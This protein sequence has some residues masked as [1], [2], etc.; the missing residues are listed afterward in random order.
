MPTPL[1]NAMLLAAI[2]CTVAF[3]YTRSTTETVTDG[4]GSRTVQRTEVGLPFSPWYVSE[5]VQ[6]NGSW[7]WTAKPVLVRLVTT[8][9]GA[10]G[11]LALIL[12][13]SALP[14]GSWSGSWTSA[15]QEHAD[16]QM[17]SST[18][19]VGRTVAH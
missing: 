4:E 14:C 17:V 7:N 9:S 2:G 3:F 10:I 16:S 12:F 1:K 15:R 5:T 13:G 19:V 11:L 18:S 6:S 8:W